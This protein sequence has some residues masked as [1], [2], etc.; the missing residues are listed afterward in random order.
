METKVSAKRV[1]SLVNTFG[2]AGGFVVDSDGKSGGVGMFWSSL[3]V[4]DVKSFN[5]HHIDVVVQCK[6]GSL[7]PR[8]LRVSMVSLVERIDTL[9]GHFYD[10]YIISKI[11]CGCLVVISMKHYMARNTLVSMQER[12]G[13]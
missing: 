6:D 5:L 4:V 7:P 11:F 10:D 2:F 13:R 12:N 8:A 9:L 1:E 3:V